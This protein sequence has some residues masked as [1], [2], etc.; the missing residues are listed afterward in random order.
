MYSKYKFNT[1]HSKVVRMNANK[2]LNQIY[3]YFEY[4]DNENEPYQEIFCLS[5]GHRFQN[6]EGIKGFK[7]CANKELNRDPKYSRSHKS[8]SV[9]GLIAYLGITPSDF[10]QLINMTKEHE[11]IY[12]WFINC[13][14]D[15]VN[16]KLQDKANRNAYG[17]GVYACNKLG[18]RL[19]GFDDDRN[20][21]SSVEIRY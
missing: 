17:T 8:I 9:E 18:Y 16:N 13:C 7:C 4:L 2:F 12:E 6:I 20:N 19:N 15:S 11:R 3:N 21:I 14:E 5:C 10:R 1:N